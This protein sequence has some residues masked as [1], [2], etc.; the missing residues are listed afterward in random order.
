[1]FN[2]DISKI[3]PFNI[4]LACLFVV[5][6]GAS[7]NVFV[8]ASGV[9]IGF[10][11]LF[12]FFWGIR[13]EGILAPILVFLFGL[14]Q[15][16]LT[17]AALGTW[18]LVF[19]VFFALSSSQVQVIRQAATGGFLFIFVILVSVSYGLILATSFMFYR[20]EIDL[21]SLF[22]SFTLTAIIIPTLGLFI[23]RVL[24]LD[25]DRRTAL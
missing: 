19:S 4:I 10:Y 1:M 9:E 17:G 18:P 23:Q 7:K 3:D 22:W 21:S 15:D 14:L 25:S 12:L 24:P 5:S 8:A 16:A 2:T 6:I 11:F 20:D 13:S